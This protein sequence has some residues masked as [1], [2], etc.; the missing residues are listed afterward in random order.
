MKPETIELT[1]DEL[2]L[3]GIEPRLQ[4]KAVDAMQKEL[5]RLLSQ[6]GVPPALSLAGTVPNLNAKNLK[7]SPGASPEKIGAQLAYS[8]YQSLEKPL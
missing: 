8:L 2:T 1:I 3:E 5:T 7:I 4:K 6:K